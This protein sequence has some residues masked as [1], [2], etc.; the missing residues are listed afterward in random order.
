MLETLSIHRYLDIL[1]IYG[2]NPHGADNQQETSGIEFE[3]SSTTKRQTHR[4]DGVI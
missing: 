4:F 3:G 2:E 1:Y